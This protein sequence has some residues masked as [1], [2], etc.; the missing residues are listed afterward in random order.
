MGGERIWPLWDGVTS[1]AHAESRS[2]AHPRMRWPRAASLSS[3][4][5]AGGSLAGDT[6]GD[7]ELYV[8]WLQIV[9]FLP[10][11]AFGTP[12]WLCCDAWVRTPR[13]CGGGHAGPDVTNTPKSH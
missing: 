9:T 1:P 6:P 3:L 2:G 13:P 12:P 10:V 7:P 8:R 5:R 4:S 11:M